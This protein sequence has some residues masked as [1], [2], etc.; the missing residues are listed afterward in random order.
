MQGQVWEKAVQYLYRAGVKA[1]GRSTYREAV[2]YL[3][4][5]LEALHHLPEQRGIRAQAVDLR[6]ALCDALAALG[7]L[8]RVTEVLR[9][10]EQLA[11]DLD[12]VQRLGQVSLFLSADRF[13]MG[14][15]DQ[16]IAIGQRVLTLA[17]ASEHLGLQVGGH[18]YLSMAYVSKG[19]YRQAIDCCRWTVTA[20]AGARLHERFGHNILPAVNAR[21]SLARSLAEVGGFAEAI[22]Y[23]A[24]GLRIAE[25]AAHPITLVYGCLG[26]GVPYLL[27]GAYD[28]ALPQLE[29]AMGICRDLSILFHFPAAALQLGTAYTLTGQVTEALIL[30]E[31]M[32]AQDRAMGRQGAQAARVA[33]L[34]EATLLAGHPEHA[35][36][37]A[38]HALELSRRHG[39]RGAQAYILR[40]LGDITA[41]CAPLDAQEVEAHYRQ[42]LT[43]AEELGMRPLQAHCHRGLGTLYATIGQREQARA[44]LAAAIA[45]YRAMGMTFWLP[46]AEAA[47]AHVEGC[48]GI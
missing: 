15:Y 4:Q 14:E 18:Y 24:E 12:D 23:G 34:S 6:F 17:A 43:L 21:W 8:G 11:E 3:E 31:Q 9:E 45:L 37:L 28:K 25:T 10:A 2:A 39:E 1:S 22:A 19:A 48:M 33:A 5:A 44:E 26:V 35:S 42:A 36:D 16:A 40:L 47:L 13:R 27:Q 41:Q 46:Q 7:A 30:L 32:L 29:R 20:L 38:R